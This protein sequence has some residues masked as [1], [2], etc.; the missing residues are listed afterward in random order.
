MHQVGAYL[1]RLLLAPELQLENQGVHKLRFVGKQFS[2]LSTELQQKAI[3]YT[4]KL[5]LVSLYGECFL[6]FDGAR[7]NNVGLV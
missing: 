3:C 1:L 5:A 6:H 7:Q 2:A 4:P